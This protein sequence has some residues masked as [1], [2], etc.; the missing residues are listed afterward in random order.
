MEST[1]SER[2]IRDVDRKYRMKI[3][4]VTLDLL[5]SEM[6]HLRQ[7]L[8]SNNQ[9]LELIAQLSGVISI[10]YKDGCIRIWGFYE[11][12]D[13]AVQMIQKH[14]QHVCRSK[15]IP[16]LVRKSIAPK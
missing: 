4:L 13:R 7:I 14:I 16:F 5:P 6:R 15:M 1:H 8:G 11:T 2:K 9:H 12:P 10:I 3:S